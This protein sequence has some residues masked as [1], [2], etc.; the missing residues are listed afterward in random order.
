MY[1]TGPPIQGIFSS[2]V[3]KVAFVDPVSPVLSRLPFRVFTEDS[4]VK[5]CWS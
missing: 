4:R 2:Q 1:L 5:I 3:P